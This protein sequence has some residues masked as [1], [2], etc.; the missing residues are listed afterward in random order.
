VSFGCAL[1]FIF[2]LNTQLGFTISQIIAAGSVN[3]A[4]AYRNITGD[5]ANPFPSFKHQ[6]DVTYPGTSTITGPNPDNPYP[7]EKKV[8][9]HN[10][11]TNETQFWFMNVERIARRA[12]VVDEDGA[13]ALVGPPWRILSL[14]TGD[15]TGDG[16]SEILWHNSLTNDIQ[17]WFMNGP[18]IKGRNAGA[19]ENGAIIRVGEP[20]S[21]AGVTGLASDSAILWH[22][23]AVWRPRSAADRPR[24]TLCMAGQSAVNDLLDLTGQPL[25]VRPAGDRSPDESDPPMPQRPQMPYGLPGAAGFVGQIC[26][27]DNRSHAAWCVK[28]RAVPRVGCGAAHIAHN[29]C[30]TRADGLNA[31]LRATVDTMEARGRR[32]L[33]TTDPGS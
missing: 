3:L 18:Q 22:N 26:C 24:P 12:T 9:W 32:L 8:A 28:H 21:N 30:Q 16:N 4:S 23:R 17:F 25:L 27:Y 19:D 2:Y 1:A 10:S 5:T 13:A 29:S 31:K 15:I 14:R 33:R 7:I 11:S 20:W 6:L